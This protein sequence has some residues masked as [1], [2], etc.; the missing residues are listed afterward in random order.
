MRKALSSLLLDEN[1]PIPAAPTHMVLTEVLNK[2]LSVKRLTIYFNPLDYWDIDEYIS[3]DPS[4]NIAK[5][6]FDHAKFVNYD[7]S[8]L[9]WTAYLIEVSSQEVLHKF[10]SY[11]KERTD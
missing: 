1:K 4:V 3:L 10:A 7:N 11:S 5:H 9:A 8:V 6:I 2:D